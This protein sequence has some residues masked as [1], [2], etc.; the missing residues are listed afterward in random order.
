MKHTDYYYVLD[1]YCSNPKSGT[2]SYLK[3]K[4][5]NEDSFFCGLKFIHFVF[6]GTSSSSSRMKQRICFAQI[7][8]NDILLERFSVKMKWAVLPFFWELILSVFGSSLTSMRTS[9]KLPQRN[10]L[11]NPS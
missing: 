4:A 5:T 11:L 7:R 3:K 6:I 8:R 9:R 1:I 10:I 2:F